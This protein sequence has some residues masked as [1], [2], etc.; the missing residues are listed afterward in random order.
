MDEYLGK[1]LQVSFR[2][3]QCSDFSWNCTQNK[4]CKELIYSKIKFC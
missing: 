3:M 4:L 2:K 1:N